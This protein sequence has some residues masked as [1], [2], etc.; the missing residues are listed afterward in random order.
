MSK[1]EP[2]K[3]KVFVSCGQGSPD[4]R[5]TAAEIAEV[6]RGLGFDPYVA[7]VE[8]TLK[9]LRENIFWN[10]ETAEYFLFVDFRREQLANSAEYR[11]SLFTNQELGVASYLDIDVIVLRQKGVKREDG[12]MRFLQANAVEFENLDQVPE[13]VS[14]RVVEAGWQPGWKRHLR[15]ALCD[16]L[17]TDAV[18]QDGRL[19]R[20][21]HLSVHNEHYRRPALMCSATV[22]SI[23]EVQMARQIPSRPVELHWAGSSEQFVTVAP[24][25]SREVD[26]GFI[27]HGDPTRFVFNSFSTGTQ[28]MPPLVGPGWFHVAYIVTS[29]NFPSAR[30]LVRLTIGSHVAHG[31]VELLESGSA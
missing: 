28:Y 11:G 10:L 13:L 22:E 25:R 2:E 4:E 7:I 20:F 1:D 18:A 8:Q 27:P 29:S 30:C 21:F 5:K 17:F 15:L 24:G 19:N 6:L 16:P 23:E 12:L 3:T 9:G 26:L 31:E 14:K